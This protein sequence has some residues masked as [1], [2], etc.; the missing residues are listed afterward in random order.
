MLDIIAP[1]NT[2]YVVFSRAWTIE[3]FRNPT[4]KIQE[5]K[6]VADNLSLEWYENEFEEFF[7]NPI[8]V[9][10]DSISQGIQNNIVTAVDKGINILKYGVGSEGV[11]PS[12]FRA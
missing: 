8:F 1:E 2:S 3:S 7:Y 4:N 9:R 11:P 5:L 12:C 10:G 6:V